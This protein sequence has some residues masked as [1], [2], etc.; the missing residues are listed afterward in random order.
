MGGLDH[1][2]LGDNEVLTDNGW[3]KLSEI[4][5][6][7]KAYTYNTENGEIE[8]SPILKVHKFHYQGEMLRLT[9][10]KKLDITMTPNHRMILW[11]RKGEPYYV[12][13]EMA[14][15]MWKEKSSTLSHSS[16]RATGKWRGDET[17]RTINISNYR[18]PVKAFSALMGLWV[19]TGS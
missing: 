12:T 2:L 10:G 3:I 5:K 15:E 1:C 11:S 14:E 8:L 17:T 16:L 19:A 4:T 13:A 6:D 7:S 18:I 9:N